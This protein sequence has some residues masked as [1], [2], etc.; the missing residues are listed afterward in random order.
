[1]SVEYNWKI[2][3]EQKEVK[4]AGGHDIK[5]CPAATKRR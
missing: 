2:S 4:V 3:E 1:M 5:P